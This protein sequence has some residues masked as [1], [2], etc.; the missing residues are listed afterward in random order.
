[1]TKKSSYVG[2]LIAAHPVN[3]R[4]SLDHAVILIVTHTPQI[5]IG[6]QINRPL[7]ELDLGTVS[8]QSGIEYDGEDPVFYG[9][10][11]NSNKIHVVHSLDWSSMTTV[12]I[13]PD[14]GVTN[15]LSVLA[16][17]AQGEGPFDFRACAG[18]WNWPTKELTQQ[19]NGRRDPTHKWELTPATLENVFDSDVELEQWRSVIED[20]ARDQV[21]N[22]L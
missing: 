19:L 17:I 7:Y 15:D 21:A 8:G 13:T 2:K 14:I 20:C 11:I 5:C 10:K 3:P 18:F 4:D 9:G 6:I 12:Q 22:W 16:A 1:M